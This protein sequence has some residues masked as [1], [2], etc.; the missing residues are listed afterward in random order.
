[1]TSLGGPQVLRCPPPV[2]RV[3]QPNQYYQQFGPVTVPMPGPQFSGHMIPPGTGAQYYGPPTRHP[4]STTPLAETRVQQPG[5]PPYTIVHPSVAGQHS[6]SAPTPHPS[7]GMQC[8]SSSIQSQPPGQGIVGP[9]HYFAGSPVQYPTNSIQSNQPPDS[10]RQNSVPNPFSLPSQTGATDTGS[11]SNIT[12]NTQAAENNSK[13]QK[14]IN[15][16]NSTDSSQSMPRHN[17][18]KVSESKEK[19]HSHKN[20]TLP[21]EKILA[22]VESGKTISSSQVNPLMISCVKTIKMQ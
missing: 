12:N 11:G 21:Q 14:G 6:F 3:V 8:I 18:V 16:N 20:E 5:Q 2:S 19:Q 1:M 15:S 22:K 10:T 17:V 7:S 13:P 9:E 4:I